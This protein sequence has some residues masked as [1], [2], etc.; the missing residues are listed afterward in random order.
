[1]GGGNWSNDAYA[2]I[3]HDYTTKSVDQIFTNKNLVD[4]MS[5]KDVKFRES[6]DSAEHPE[7]LPV[8]IFV[9]VTGSMGDIP[10]NII[11]HKLGK[12][13]DVL[14]KH[15]IA[16]PQLL[17]GAIGDHIS[18]NVPLQVG[19][20]E[21]STEKINEC[22]K[23]I[24]IEGNGGG[25]RHESYSLG[26][27][28][29]AQHTSLDSF[30]KRGQ[31]GFLFTIGDEATWEDYSAESMKDIFG[32]KEA[33]EMTAKASLNDA[34]RTY[35]VFHIHCEDGSYPST[36]PKGAGVVKEWR[37]LLKERL[38][39]LEDQNVIAETIATAIVACLG[40]DMKH[41]MNDFDKATAGKVGTALAN[42]G[43]FKPAIQKEGALT[44]K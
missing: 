9:D 24:Y 43:S 38:I 13:M 28:F 44:L 17:F 37:G 42:I 15:G 1:M 41:V 29:A 11:R 7:S 4:T 12:L 39:L 21:S 31:K 3:Q 26:W 34:L 25:Q 16:H 6:R 32:G 33:G 14:I 22:L 8:I 2:H 23:S 30:E 18:D 40:A 5:P 20:F 19:Q 35:E 27:H 10:E 36:E